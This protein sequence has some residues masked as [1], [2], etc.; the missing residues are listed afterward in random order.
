[1]R[2]I[3]VATDGSDAAD[4]A[5]DFAADLAGRF[6]ADLLLTHVILASATVLAGGGFP[7]PVTDLRA[8]IRIENASLSELLTDAGNDILAKAKERA[9]AK[10]ARRVHTELRTGDAAEMVLSVAKEH[11]ADV[12]V[13]GKRGRGRLA[14]LLL[15]STSQ[16][17]MM[18]ASCAVIIVP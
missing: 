15:G 11:D 18:L 4:R 3:V 6:A 10:G 8:P 5:V 17:V 7:H 14:G 12:I 9:E 13:L 16:K 2:C 1:M